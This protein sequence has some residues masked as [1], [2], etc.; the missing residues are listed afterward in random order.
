MC[1]DCVGECKPCSCFNP[2][3]PKGQRTPEWYNQFADE[4]A[5]SLTMDR[6][7][8]ANIIR[9]LANQMANGLAFL[10]VMNG[11]LNV[12]ENALKLPQKMICMGDTVLV[13]EPEEGDCW[14]HSFAGR[15]VEKRPDDNG[16]WFIGVEDQTG[17][18]FTVE[19]SRLT[20]V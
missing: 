14:N 8:G 19:E 18:F 12:I 10:E 3:L 9:D 11:K 6:S 1:D 15:T 2:Y 13:P 4:F 17:D 7:E 20:L 5:D 16:K